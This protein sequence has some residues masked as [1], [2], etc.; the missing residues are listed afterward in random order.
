MTIADL[1][2]GA[3]ITTSVV[4]IVMA[5]VVPAQRSFAVQQETADLL[6]RVRVTVDAIAADLR[7]AGLVLP[8]RAGL[9]GDG[10]GNGVFY[11]PA[12]VGVL[13]ERA[14]AYALGAVIPG[15][16][17]SYFVA[18]GD[19]D[20]HQ[21]MRYDGL[22]TTMPLADN[23]VQLAF[24]FF[25][26]AQPPRRLPTTGT[27]VSLPVTYGPSPPAVG[28]D[29]PDDTWGVGENCTFA[30]ANGQHTPRLEL[31]AGG[32]L[33]VL[34]PAQLVDGPWCPDSAHPHRFDADL[35]RI[36]RVR[37]RVRMQPTATFRSRDMPGGRAADGRAVSE[38]EIVIDVAPRNLGLSR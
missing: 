13:F 22:D 19:G 11:R 12:T 30:L 6:Q 36:R 21:V 24:D 16:G 37:L 8:Y 26:E 33:V 34:S 27:E 5:A 7:A 18:D 32:D 31:L 20:G 17:A 10:A 25:G 1:L 4:G 23:I 29:N 2:V 28:A 35:L 9:N 38:Q 3:S 15:P 14:E